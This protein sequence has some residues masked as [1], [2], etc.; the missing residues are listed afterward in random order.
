LDDNNFYVWGK[1]KNFGARVSVVNPAGL[2]SK[3]LKESLQKRGITVDGESSSRDW[4]SAEALD[5]SEANELARYK[6]R[7][8]SKLSNE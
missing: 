3:N 8:S 4:K 2:V 1:V 6:A 7:R 5:V